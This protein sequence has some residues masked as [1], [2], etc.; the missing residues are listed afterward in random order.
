MEDITINFPKRN[1]HL[2][3]ERNTIHKYGLDFP[4]E[5]D[6]RTL[7]ITGI[8]G[9]GKSSLVRNIC[10]QERVHYD[11]QIF[12]LLKEKPSVWL[13]EDEKLHYNSFNDFSKSKVVDG[14]FV[15]EL[16]CFKR[17]HIHAHCNEVCESDYDALE[18][19]NSVSIDNTIK[20]NFIFEFRQLE[21]TLIREARKKRQEEETLMNI[22]P[23]FKHTYR[24][25][26]EEGIMKGEY[27]LYQTAHKLFEQGADVY[28][29][30]SF[31]GTPLRFLE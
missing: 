11:G 22:P 31:E 27:L 9:T 25:H 13:C 6:N 10:K 30:T 3:Q 5:I 18:I 21:P 8:S 7:F 28:I 23:W 1:Y 19:E 16:P 15:F 14:H 20:E 29:R 26:N 24:P 4:S 12:I 17:N 2:Y